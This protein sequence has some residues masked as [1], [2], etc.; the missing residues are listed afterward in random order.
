MIGNLLIVKQP[1]LTIYYK[2]KDG[3]GDI[4]KYIW[5]FNNA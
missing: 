1:P 2:L 4:A 5:L 3:V